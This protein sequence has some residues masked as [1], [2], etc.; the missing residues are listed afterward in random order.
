[1]KGALSSQ[2]QVTIPKGVREALGLPPGDQIEFEVDGD[3]FI[4]RRRPMGANLD[5]FIGL[6]GD[7]RSTDEVM[8]E[9]RPERAWDS[10]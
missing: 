7:G 5:R 2:G 3:T 8:A 6:L 10:S 9:L 4:G 1:M